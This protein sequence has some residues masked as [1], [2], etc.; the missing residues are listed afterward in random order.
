MDVVFLAGLFTRGP[1]RRFSL[2]QS[3]L[4]ATYLLIV[5]SV[6]NVLC[7]LLSLHRAKDSKGKKNKKHSFKVLNNT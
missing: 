3:C 4:P 7:V 6:F 5:L 2:Q 1:E